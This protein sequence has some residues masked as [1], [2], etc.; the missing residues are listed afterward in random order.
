MASAFMLFRQ[1]GLRHLPVVD[2]DGDL[3]VPAYGEMT[4][5]LIPSG[6]D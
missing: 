4:P 5:S 3:C 2:S 1:M 6:Y